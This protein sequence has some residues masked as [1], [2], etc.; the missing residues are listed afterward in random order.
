MRECVSK[1]RRER[2]REGGKTGPAVAYQQTT[3]Q[4]RLIFNCYGSVI[5]QINYRT[6]RFAFINDARDGCPPFERGYYV[7]I[8]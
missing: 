1:A 6:D 7:I 5:K 2:E 3:A 4:P 8:S